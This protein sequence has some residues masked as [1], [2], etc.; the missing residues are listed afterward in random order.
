MAHCTKA[1]DRAGRRLPREP[2][3]DR[4]LATP[5]DLHPLNL[6]PLTEQD[7]GFLASQGLIDYSLLVGL[8]DERLG[9]LGAPTP[10]NLHALTYTSLTYTP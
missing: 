2:G 3:P 4:L 6:H 9:G 10:L 5:L 1:L 8:S 7:A